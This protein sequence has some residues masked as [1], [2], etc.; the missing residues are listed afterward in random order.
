M[1][2]THT[3]H[4]CPTCDGRGLETMTEY[5]RGRYWDVAVTC[6][7]CD[8][9]GTYTVE[10]E[11][12]ATPLDP[13]TVPDGYVVIRN[14]LVEAPGY[15]TATLTRHAQ[16]GFDAGLQIRPAHEPGAVLVSASD[17]VRW[18]RVTRRTCDCTAG[19]HGISCMH[20]ALAIWLADIDG[21]DL[22]HAP[23]ERST[24]VAA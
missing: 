23:G 17:G 7:D 19:Q 1:A 14:G 2:T 5:Y 8:G 10:T 24:A 15:T 11:T 20:R 9:S 3:T 6:T 12:P 18:H 13:A 21:R 16:R 22:T 4:P